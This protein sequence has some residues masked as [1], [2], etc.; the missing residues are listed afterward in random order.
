[1]K[2]LIIKLG[3]TLSKVKNLVCPPATQDL[4]LNTKNRDATIKKYNYG[5]L[6]VDEPGD[7][8]QK[9]AKYWKT[10]EEAAKKS[11]CGNCV[12]FD[13][14]DR[15]K[16]CMPG[17][18]FDEDGEL[19]YCWM[20]H[21]K[22]HS[23]RACHTWAKGGP[24][25]KEAE[26]AEW[27]GKAKL[28]ETKP[29]AEAEAGDLIVSPRIMSAMEKRIQ[30]LEKEKREKREKEYEKRRI[31][32]ALED[33]GL[34]H[35]LDADDEGWGWSSLEEV[36]RSGDWVGMSYRDVVKNLKKELGVR[37]LDKKWYKKLR[38]NH[39]A[40]VK[41]RE[42]YRTRKNPAD[43]AGIEMPVGQHNLT[44]AQTRRLQLKQYTKAQLKDDPDL[45]IDP[46]TTGL[47]AGPEGGRPEGVALAMP[48]KE[49]KPSK[50][51]RKQAAAKTTAKVDPVTGKKISPKPKFTMGQFGK[52]RENR[53]RFGFDDKVPFEA[54][55]VMD[56]KHPYF[57]LT[58]AE[59]KEFL[60]SKRRT[61]EPAKAS[62]AATTT[63]P[64]AKPAGNLQYKEHSFE[65]R[66][67]HVHTIKGFQQGSNVVSIAVKGVGK[68]AEEAKKNAQAKLNNRLKS[69]N[70]AVRATTKTTSGEDKKGKYTKTTTQGTVS[71]ANLS[72]KDRK[73]FNAQRQKI[74][75][76]L[77][78]KRK[79]RN[80]A[81]S[82][83]LAMAQ[84][85][86]AQSG[87]DINKF[88]QILNK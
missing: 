29:I 47:E 4:A 11:L 76:T 7:Y 66:G 38:R 82:E 16:K 20:H 67:T 70:P 6:N 24:I 3:K 1:M 84:T 65:L 27:Q 30:K 55:V 23:A 10:T 14:S 28:E 63:K 80:L 39:P 60:A 37:K 32:K 25:K 34:R 49:P 79:N 81:S 58:S 54:G 40:R 59:I 21:F 52:A 87:G 8:W 83:A 56:P 69:K 18:T 17:D 75:N 19:G 57:G 62:T 43:K 72:D 2:K 26:S 78:K 5:P 45:M 68:T 36:N 51:G 85:A 74:F 41:F 42:W 22:C 86:L 13:I 31:K 46:P 12:A 71:I 35:A 44:P 64:S 33:P 88:V 15:M 50:P 9:I 53:K 77:M 61:K 48:K 73:V